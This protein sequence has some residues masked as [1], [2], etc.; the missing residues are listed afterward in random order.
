[1][2][3]A[4]A[5]LPVGIMAGGAWLA[6]EAAWHSAE[7]ELQRT[8]DAVAQY[9]VRVFDA[10]RIAAA[11]VNDVIRGLS[12]AEI[13]EREWELHRKL[14]EL[15]EDV[16]LVR[17]IGVVD[18]DGKFLL[19]SAAYPA[20]RDADFSDREWMQVLRRPDAPPLHISHV[21]L[22]PLDNQAYLA[23]S[24]RRTASGNGSAPDQF[25]GA[26]VFAIPPQA[27]SAGFTELTLDPGDSVGL[28]RED[29]YYLALL[30]L[31]RGVPTVK[32]SANFVAAVASRPERVIFHSISPLDSTE[33]ISA[34][35]RLPGLPV[36]AGT[37]RTQAEISAAWHEDVFR[38]FAIV[39]PAG[40]LLF[41][42]ALIALRRAQRAATAQAELVRESSRHAAVEAAREAERQAAEQR[43]L[44]MREV[45]HRSRNTLS[46]IQMALRLGLRGRTDVR[47]LAD[48]LEA[49]I[50]ALGRAQALLS[51]Q[52]WTGTDIRTLIE[53]EFSALQPGAAEEVKCR[54]TCVGPSVAILPAATQPLAM[55]IHE[56]G[57]NAVK[58]GAWSN[59]RGHIAISWE[60]RADG[61]LILDWRESGGPA[62]KAPDRRGFGMNLI[63][64]TIEGQLGGAITRSWG[65]DGFSCTVTLPARVFVAAAAAA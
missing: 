33:R 27:L 28:T 12:D 31:Q 63:D 41:A 37:S 6:R 32:A 40:A 16:P 18:R 59:S 61:T 21:Y 34:L 54:L 60:V 22:S 19:S 35:R 53:S 5:V 15:A 39:G 45:E 11:R 52:A 13:R 44:L 65:H 23:I 64:T 51:R 58:Y 57:T 1:M 4:A 36:Y 62:T 50:V 55:A 14:R 30:P 2:V 8:S 17:G 43:E 7:R 49:R 48:E 10:Q 3:V 38:L 47:G 56:L 25:D 46:L 42:F 20:P 24:R 9:S 26:I 29:G